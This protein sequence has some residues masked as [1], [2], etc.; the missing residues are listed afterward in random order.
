M[1]VFGGVFWCFGGLLMVLLL[2]SVEVWVMLLNTHLRDF[3]RLS[4][5]GRMPLK[6]VIGQLL[7]DYSDYRHIN[8]I[9]GVFFESLQKAPI[10]GG[11]R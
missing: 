3:A 8:A 4:F 2:V 5:A 11:S 1:L 6:I 7:M 10:V 9:L